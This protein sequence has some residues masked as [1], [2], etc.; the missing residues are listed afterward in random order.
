MVELGQPS[1][2]SRHAYY[3]GV[4]GAADR[5]KIK[6]TR[7]GDHDGLATRAIFVEL[8]A[9]CGA[10][11]GRAGCGLWRYRHQPPI[12]DTGRA[13]AH[14]DANRP[15]YPGLAFPVVLDA[16]DSR[17]SEERRVGKECVSTCRSRWSPYH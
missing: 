15:G 7:I 12:Y 5:R 17:R 1:G 14:A 13:L 16:D 10:M 9:A 11:A 2:F 6:Q 3:S 8:I 4:S